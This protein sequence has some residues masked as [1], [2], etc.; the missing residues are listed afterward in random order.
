MMPYDDPMQMMAPRRTGSLDSMDEPDFNPQDM[1]D[2]AQSMLLTPPPP[3]ITDILDGASRAQSKYQR[4]NERIQMNRALCRMAEMYA[5]RLR[6]SRVTN[7]PSDDSDIAISLPNTMLM[8]HAR[9]LGSTRYIIRIAAR[10]TQ[11]KA[12]RDAE[13]QDEFLDEARAQFNRRHQAAGGTAMLDELAGLHLLECGHYY[14]IVRLDPE[15]KGL[16]I[17]VEWVDALEMY[18]VWGAKGIKACYRIVKLTTEQIRAQFG[19]ELYPDEKGDEEHDVIAFYDDWYLAV[20]ADNDWLKPPTPHGYPHGCPVN[21]AFAHGYSGAMD[22]THL[23]ADE[24]EAQRGRGF[25]ESKISEFEQMVNLIMNQV[26][27]AHYNS[28]PAMLHKRKQGDTDAPID[29][30][31]GKMNKAEGDHDVSPILFGDSVLSKDATQFF[32][33]AVQSGT[34][35]LSTDQM[36]ASGFDRILAQLRQGGT[37]D[38]VRN[39]LKGVLERRYICVLSL[40]RAYGD[41]TDVMI[42]DPMSG[43]MVKDSFTWRGV[44]PHPIVS[45]SWPPFTP[46]E[47]VQMGPMVATMVEAGLWDIDTAHAYLGVDNSAQVKRNVMRER[48][49]KNPLAEQAAAQINTLLYFREMFEQYQEQGDHQAAQWFAMMGQKLEQ[50]MMQSLMPQPPQMPAM[51]QP[52]LPASPG[53]GP[54]PAPPGIPPQSQPPAMRNPMALPD[55]GP[56]VPTGQPNPLELL[57][58]QSG[59]TDPYG[60]R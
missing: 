6:L 54:A 8:Q 29:I 33:D 53:M 15:Y 9:D 26:W 32:F 22:D 14:E 25:L 37:L 48:A 59:I 20:V 38:F 28:N 16:P 45:V 31:M 39:A 1:V 30:K 44:D 7:D 12:I 46:A 13:K 19:Q 27:Q 5:A 58:A 17:C 4:R 21:A 2:V 50:E 49:L 57:L 18:P 23:Q 10:S 56:G 43:R 42:S 51:G 52:Q 35:P 11:R 34:I 3:D 40:F 41:T 47:Q 60:G 24:A 55:M 36:A